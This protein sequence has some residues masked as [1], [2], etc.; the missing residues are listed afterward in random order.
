MSAGAIRL[1]LGKN[2]FS[3]RDPSILQLATLRLR[4]SPGPGSYPAACGAAVVMML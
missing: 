3:R 2:E 1:F 4:Y